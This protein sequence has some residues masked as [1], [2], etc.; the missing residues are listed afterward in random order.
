VVTS[1]KDGECNGQQYVQRKPC[2]CIQMS[3][4]IRDAVVTN[5]CLAI[6]S[7]MYL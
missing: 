1:D 5:I 2:L 4:V 3:R 7:W 6:R